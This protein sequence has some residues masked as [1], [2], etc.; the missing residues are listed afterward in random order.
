MELPCRAKGDQL[1]PP[2]EL[3]DIRRRLRLRADQHDLT[4]VVVGAFEHRTRM[5][6]FNLAPMW[7][8]PAGARAIG[9]ALLDSGL[10]KT[11][12]VLQQWSRRFRPSLARLDGRVPDLLLISSMKVHWGPARALLRDACTLPP[13]A[14]P[15]ILAGGPKMFYEPWDAFATPEDPAS[16]DVAVTGEEYVL[17]A[18]LERLMELRADREPLRQ[19][20]LRARDGGLLDDVPGLVYALGDG[21][22]PDELVDTGIQRLVG[23]LDEQPYSGLG[24][25]ILEPPSGRETL[26]SAPLPRE[27]VGRHSKL[28]PLVLTLGCHFGCPYCPIPAYNQRQCR[29]KSG[30]RIAEEMGRII[31][32]YGTRHFFGADDNLFNDRDRAV[33]LGETLARTEFAGGRPHSRPRWATEATVHDTW[34]MRDHL[35]LFHKAGLRALWIGVED[36]TATL[37]RKGQSV[38]RTTETFRLLR[39]A[40]ILPMPMLMHHESQP[41]YTRGQPYGLLNQ[42]RL[43]RQAGSMSVQVLMITPAPG[44]KIYEQTYTSGQAFTHV[45]G[46]PVEEHMVDG[47]YVIAAESDRIWR[48]QLNLMVAYLYFFNPLRLLVSLVRPGSRMY[49]A[50]F[51]FQATGIIALAKTIYRTTGWMLGLRRGPIARASQPPLSQLPMRNPAGDVA[52]HAIP[53][54]GQAAT[55]AEQP[56]DVY[57]AAG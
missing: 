2:G 54:T 30:G 38:D 42:I 21:P 15:L 5:M 40:G 7:M 25:S 34:T 39:D 31:D 43:L 8:V 33:E 3:V 16:A 45:A 49:G 47:N 53:G 48:K 57:D 26:A 1:L 37:V 19:T 12:I 23:D 24:Y 29:T 4:S 36:I 14:R 55:P 52:A 17:L 32:E 35:R 6:P 10:T 13:D 11:R 9:S 51:G 50:N 28:V 56:R 20:F 27:R 46:R 41:L 44:S 18:L 22:V